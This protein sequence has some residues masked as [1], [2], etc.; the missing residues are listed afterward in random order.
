MSSA[1]AQSTLVDTARTRWPHA[2]IDMHRSGLGML[3]ASAPAWLERGDDDEPLRIRA[4]E[5]LVRSVQQAIVSVDAI[6]CF[7][8]RHTHK[9]IAHKNK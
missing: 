4:L 9:H 6:S 8:F 7:G 5:L 1:D 3:H 2:L